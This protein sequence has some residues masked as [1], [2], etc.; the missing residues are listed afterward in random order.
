MIENNV[1]KIIKA[2]N[3][4]LDE[5]ADDHTIVFS[6]E[7]ER[8]EHFY[9]FL[10]LKIERWKTSRRCIYVGCTNKSVRKSHTISKSNNLKLICENGKLLTPFLDDKKGGMNVREIGLN[11]ASTFPG[12]CIKHESLF[13]SFEKTGKLKV[14]KDF[15]LQI[16]RTICREI[17]VKE[18][19][20]EYFNKIIA[21]YIVY[22]DK[23][24]IILIKEKLGADFVINNQKLINS[25]RFQECKTY[26]E[27]IM[28]DKLDSFAKDLEK[29]R[30]EFLKGMMQDLEEM[31]TVN[32]YA[33]AICID[34]E[35]PVALAGRGNFVVDDGKN[36]DVVVIINTIPFKNGT[37]F[38]LASLNKYKKFIDSYVDYYQQHPLLLI[39]MV[40]NWM[41]HGSD[42]WF[43]KPS[44]WNQLKDE[45]KEKFLGE[46][47]DDSKNIGF[48]F[49]YSVFNGLRKYI[50]DKMKIETF[51]KKNQN[52]FEKEKLKILCSKI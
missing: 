35:I 48:P 46:I 4:V 16:Y 47:L 51:P 50:F 21:D 14:T 6:N 20:I 36:S 28:L 29:L 1:K 9:K 23:K 26:I 24:L 5:Y 3:E 31:K 18:V 40:E 11:E 33:I 2:F 19:Y 32:I 13:S 52:F 8:N 37:Y 43:I 41:V 38:I 30:N 45:Y 49:E 34:I 39:N 17:L 10:R 7:S 12:F 27:N 15:Q 42:H 25:M 44:I 22:R